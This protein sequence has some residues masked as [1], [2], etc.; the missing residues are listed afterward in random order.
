MPPPN[1]IG[2][3]PKQKQNALQAAISSWLDSL[4]PVLVESITER[5][6]ADAG[7]NVD[8]K[9]LLLA[10]APKR[11]VVYE[12]MVLLPSGSFTNQPWPA[13]LSSLYPSQREALWTAILGQLSPTNKPPLTHL[14]INEGIPL[15]LPSQPSGTEG[16]DNPAGEEEHKEEN[17]LRSPTRLQPLHGSFGNSSPPANPTPSDFDSAFW[18]S[19]KQNGLVQTWAPLHTMFSRGNI[20]EKARLLSFHHR[21]RP[22]PGSGSGPGTRSEA[23]QDDAPPTA[24]TMT[25]PQAPAAD[26]RGGGGTTRSMGSSSS[27]SSRRQQRQYAVDL[28]AGIGYFAFS[29]ARLGLRVLCWELNPWS[30]E[31]LRRGAAANGFSVRV[32]VP[33]T[34]HPARLSSSSSSSFPGGGGGGG[35]G[36][37]RHLLDVEEE[38]EEEEKEEDVLA[39]DEQIVVFLEDNRHAAGRIRGWRARSGGGIEVLHVNC[40]FL[41]SSQPVWKD[42]WGMVVSG[43]GGDDGDD[44]SSNGDGA[45]GGEGDGEGQSWLHLHENVGVADIET[46]RAEI[47]GLF[48]GWA[49]EENRKQ[50]AGGRRTARVEHV[51]LVK[52]YAPG[53]WHCVFDVSITRSNA[54][55]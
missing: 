17:L 48:D 11:W 13:L 43:D 25:P 47:Q 1:K 50:G 8:T 44:G 21:T 39:G 29:Y 19:T 20:K 10:G 53:V 34:P 40:G 55:R 42:A 30:V 46:R 28:Y 14:A 2:R 45:E 33:R 16:D 49:T 26:L 5:V 18:V 7:A 9:R 27:S 52:T 3:P 41:P 31:G 4:P 35:G 12:P 36:D 38:E 22:G 15:H 6:A 37:S 54:G 51:E 32:V 24:K 23:G